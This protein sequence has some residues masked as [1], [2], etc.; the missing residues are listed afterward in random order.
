MEVIPPSDR[1][2][3]CGRRWL[4]A[5]GPRLGEQF[6]PWVPSDGHGVASPVP[7][8]PRSLLQAFLLCH[9]PSL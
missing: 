2:L 4:S 7:T 1:M 3:T 9:L 8:P 5:R 6:G